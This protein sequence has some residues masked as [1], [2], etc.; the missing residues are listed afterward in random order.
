MIKLSIVIP[1]YNESKIIPELHQRLNKTFALF[2]S[3]CNLNLNEIEIIFVNDGS[4]DDSLQQLI[5]LTETNPH[6]QVVNFSRNFGHQKAVTAGIDISVGESVVL[7]DADLQDPPEF[8]AEL[9]KKQNEGYDV[10]YAVRNKRIGESY[11]KMAT[12]KLF[13]RI[14]FRMTDISI[15]LDTGDF[16]IMRRNVVDVLKKMPETHRFIRGMVSWVGFKQIGLE[17]ERQERFAGETK[18]P[19]KKMLSFAIDALTSFSTTPLKLVTYFGFIVSLIGLLGILYVAYTKYFTNNNITGW[20]SIMVTILFMGGVQLLTLG[21]I[22]QYI[23]RIS[24]E[25]KNRPLYIIDKIYG[26]K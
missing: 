4:K 11:F 24:E 6:Y 22:G 10:V 8:I 17:Y 15:P 5:A 19:F 14:L 23:G 12:A 1:I 26:K 9:Y 20:S 21:I 3:E 13:Y 25:S 7:I 18:Y 2:K 16:R